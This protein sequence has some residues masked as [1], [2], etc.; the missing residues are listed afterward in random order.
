MLQGVRGWDSAV[1]YTP[2]MLSSLPWAG[3][4]SH[5]TVMKAAAICAQDMDPP[6]EFPGPRPFLPG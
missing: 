1:E 6:T 4:C 5:I 2:A 3:V